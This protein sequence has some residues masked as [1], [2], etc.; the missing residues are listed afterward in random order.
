MAGTVLQEFLIRLRP[1]IDEAKFRDMDSKLRSIN[2]RMLNLGKIAAVAGIAVSAAL[3]KTASDMEKLYFASQRAQTSVQNLM[4]IRFASEQIGISAEAITGAIETMATQLRSNPGLQLFFKQLSLPLLD[5]N[6]KNIINLVTRLQQMS[7]QGPFG[8]A[9]A[10]QIAAQF[11]ID[12]KT[13]FM[14]EKNLP[15][16]IRMQDQFKRGAAAWGINI[17]QQAEKFHEFMQDLR[18]LEQKIEFFAIAFG[19]KL[20][21]YADKLVNYLSRGMDLLAEWGTE[22]SGIS[23]VFAGIAASLIS[24]ASAL[25]VMKGIAATLGIGGGAAGTAAA[26]LV[27]AL[28]G[29]ALPLSLVA[30]GGLASLMNPKRG[31]QLAEGP[32]EVEAAE[33]TWQ[34]IGKMI[35]GFESFSKKIYQD[36]KGKLAIGFGHNLRSGENFPGGITDDQGLRLLAQDAQGAMETVRQLVKVPLSQNQLA[37]LTDFVY[38]VGGGNFAGSALLSR[39]NA[40]DYGAAADQFGLWNKIM[41]NGALVPSEALTQRRLGEKNLFSTPDV[42][43]NQNTNINV[44]G[45]DSPESTARAISDE[46]NRV[47]STMLRNLQGAVK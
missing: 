19:S 46:Q 25:T 33:G 24:A 2:E 36:A 42:K 34:L 31:A 7:A 4:G 8:H 12:E 17:D 38:N 40:G 23:T 14:L 9:L 11:G 35:S 29:V 43:I 3:I 32:Q 45:T 30:A 22:T 39:L 37:A 6:T 5:D 21:P 16:W 1:D 27:G 26:P 44:T 28:S 10:T 18:M 15:E 13:L 47:N 20:L 41:K